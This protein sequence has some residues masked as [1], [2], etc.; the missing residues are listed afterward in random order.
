MDPA[1]V[2]A[3]KPIEKAKEPS[4][5]R[6]SWDA[7]TSFFGI[8]SQEA[9]TSIQ[10]AESE[11]SNVHSQSTEQESRDSNKTT[12]KRGKPSFWDSESPGKATPQPTSDGVTEEYRSDNFS[13]PDLSFGSPRRK[14]PDRSSGERQT[15]DKN[16]RDNEKQPR[17]KTQRGGDRPQRGSGVRENRTEVVSR[18]ER[19]PR[20]GERK[21][22]SSSAAPEPR[23]NQHRQKDRVEADH[24]TNDATPDR[25]S[26]RRPPR[27][28][29]AEGEIE[30]STRET[31]DPISSVE[32][33]VSSQEID[34]TR[35]TGRDRVRHDRDEHRNSPPPR[36]RSDVRSQED[37]PSEARRPRTSESR[38]SE[39]GR[40]SEEVR[41][42]SR[43][44]GRSSRPSGHRDSRIEGR[45]STQ[46]NS[47]QGNETR[48][49][50]RRTEPSDAGRDSRNRNSDRSR[51]SDRTPRGERGRGPR[52]ERVMDERLPSEG[53][54][55]DGIE[56]NIGFS[57]VEDD[58]MGPSI[59]SQSDRTEEVIEGRQ[60]GRRPRGDRPR[61][62]RSNRQ[63]SEEDDRRGG[64][65]DREAVSAVAKSGKIPSWAEALE[66]IVSAN[67]ENHQRN[68]GGGGRGRGRGPRQ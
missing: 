27:R 44:G 12:A 25:R 68:T 46:S 32:S 10:S 17:D 1:Y 22:D 66:G 28:G 16:Q 8:Q 62:E 6:S 13:E 59:R 63:M 43:T 34:S 36:S 15:V 48:S 21:V 60:S 5:L 47:S 19:S 9:E 55:G 18:E 35:R 24:I 58:D 54:F 39:D 52:V 37:R 49:D 7:V 2:E 45:E 51:N 67:T 57:S 40:G 29:R 64:D 42:E 31:I 61:G 4:R 3:V 26:H 20:G 11:R 56:D 30:E 14:G 53:G 38:T 50:G 41:T 23:A 33:D 65:E